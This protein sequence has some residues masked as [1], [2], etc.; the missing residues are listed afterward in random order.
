MAEQRPAAKRPPRTAK[1]RDDGTTGF[2]AEE[3]AAMRERARELKAAKRP[4]NA[5][6]DEA[7]VVDALAAMPDE[8]RAIG[9]RLH[10]LVRETVPA[11]APRL[12]YGM[13]AYARDGK[14][15]C[16]FQGASK[17]KVRY[18]TLG[19]SD[20]ATLDDGDCWPTAFALR[21]LT[22]AVE[23]QVVALLRRA[24]G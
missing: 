8:D 15:V 19:F 7:A 12:W 17:F 9:E 10:A 21:A 20:R 14:V 2:T 18:A 5:E 11:L 13:P 6:A 23:A 4:G 16:F 1:P 22:P 3:R 24:V